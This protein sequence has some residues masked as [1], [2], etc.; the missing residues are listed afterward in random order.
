MKRREIEAMDQA[1]ATLRLIT[2][3]NQELN[4]LNKRFVVKVTE[5]VDLASGTQAELDTAK[6]MNRVIAELLTQI[7][8]LHRDDDGT[9]RE[10]GKPYP[11]PTIETVSELKP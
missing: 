4:E 9:C 10:D 3:Q 8:A 2:R 6:V 11:C 1:A 7:I 5:L